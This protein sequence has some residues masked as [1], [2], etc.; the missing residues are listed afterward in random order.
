MKSNPFYALSASAMLLGCWLLSEA[1][2]LQAGQLG[3]LLILMLVLQLYEGLLVGLGA[4]L[5][6]TGRAPR[7]G[8]TVLV[9]ESVFL[10]DAPLLAAEC[11][12]ASAPVGTGVAVALAALAVAKL[13]WVR[14]A[15][16]G[17]LSPRAAALLGGQAAFVLAVPVAAAHLAW[18]RVFGPIALYGFWWATLALPVAQRALH[19]E[20]R[21]EAAPEP[22]RSQAVWTWVPAAMA[23][24]HLWAVGYIHAIDFRPAFLAPFLLGLAATAGRE[25]LVRQVALPGLAVLVSLGQGPSLGFHLLVTGGPFVSPLCLALVG[26]AAAWGYLAW[27]DR[28]RWQLLLAVGS[29]AAG[30]LGSSISSLSSLLGRAL[31]FLGLHLP[32]DAFGWGV[33]TVVAAFV[34]LAAGARRSLGAEPR[35]PLR[36]PGVRADRSRQPWRDSAAVAL[37][38]AVFALSAMAAAFEAFPLGHPKQDGPAGLASLAAAAAFVMAVRAHGR[39]AREAKDAAAQRLAGLAM[40]ASTLGFLLAMTALSASGPHVSRSESAVIGDIRTVISAQSAYQAANGGVFE[41]RLACLQEPAGCIP[42]YARKGPAF[43]D[44]AVTSLQPKNGYKRSFVP[45]PPAEGDPAVSSKSSTSVFAYVAVPTDPGASG[46]RGF[47]GDSTSEVCFTSDGTA[48]R[49]G[50]DGL[51]DRVSCTVL[52]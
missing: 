14:R 29:G 41:S 16:P 33:L 30:L 23:L 46:I 43:L 44:A 24:L 13:A 4:F 20:T 49:I 2:H 36:G 15:V 48:P 26:V 31:R 9:L 38:L 34:L 32:T 5:V 37:A 25:Q 45:G 6:R 40:A 12:T 1:L 51:C 35:W 18:A 7:D 3:G 10:M 27:R 17:L 52:Q 19:D 47:C 8:V 50:R 22:S 28:E 39:A 21:S 11:V 42:G